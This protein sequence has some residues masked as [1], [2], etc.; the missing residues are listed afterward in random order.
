MED[1]GQCRAVLR[2][3]PGPLDGRGGFEREKGVERLAREASPTRDGAGHDDVD[4]VWYVSDCEGNES[5][6]DLIRTSF[7]SAQ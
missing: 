2:V 5:L 4:Y 7:S 1:C 3:D 6:M